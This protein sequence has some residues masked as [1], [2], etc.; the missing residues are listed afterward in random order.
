MT[1]LI[2]PQIASVVIWTMRKASVV[3]GRLSQCL[4]KGQPM[5]SL[6]EFLI[7]QL[8]LRFQSRG[9]TV[10][11]IISSISRD[12]VYVALERMRKGGAVQRAPWGTEYIY[13]LAPEID[14]LKKQ[15]D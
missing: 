5:N 15:P 1:D 8:K 3:W 12:R 14:L 11:Q 4:C 10:N 6:D 2:R 9:A 7:D 13:S